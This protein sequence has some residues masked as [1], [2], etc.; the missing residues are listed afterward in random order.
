MQSKLTDQKTGGVIEQPLFTETHFHEPQAARK[1][2]EKIRW[3]NGPECP[4]CGAVKRIFKLRG[5]S[6]RDGLYQCGNC[7]DSFTVTV[8]TAFENSK[9]SL[10]K[11]VL[12]AALMMSSHSPIRAKQIERI[13]GVTYTTAW[14]MTRRLREAEHHGKKSSQPPE[15]SRR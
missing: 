9:I 2:L 14:F 1:Y 7:R 4:H 15:G 11:W 5:P 3:P 6:Y 10:D 12:A 8:G 13:L